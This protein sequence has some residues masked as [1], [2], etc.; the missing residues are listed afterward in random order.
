M[1][2]VDIPTARGRC[3]VHRYRDLTERLKFEK[4]KIKKKSE[5]YRDR[6]GEVFPS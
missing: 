5:R 1:K 6:T 2:S 3:L 4:N